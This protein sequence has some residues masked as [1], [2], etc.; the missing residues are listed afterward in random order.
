MVPV[1]GWRGKGADRRERIVGQRP[2]QIA[3]RLYMQQ[4]FEREMERWPE[5]LSQAT[6]AGDAANWSAR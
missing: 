5:I 6:E 1:W 4:A 3:P 2:I